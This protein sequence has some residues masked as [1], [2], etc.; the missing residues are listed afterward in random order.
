MK[1][2]RTVTKPKAKAEAK[3]EALGKAAAEAVARDEADRERSGRGAAGPPPPPGAPDLSAEPTPGDG[4]VPPDGYPGGPEDLE[5]EA[6]APTISRLSF[7]QYSGDASADERMRRTAERCADAA[8]IIVLSED[9]WFCLRRLVVRGEHRKA[10]SRMTSLW[11]D[12]RL[13]R[14]S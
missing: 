6:E 9:D 11:E 8:A 3:A 5:A 10:A 7:S 4:D 2:R 13:D 14:P 12:C 1:P